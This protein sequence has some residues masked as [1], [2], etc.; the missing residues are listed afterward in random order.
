MEGLQMKQITMEYFTIL[1]LKKL[2]LNNNCID[3]G[4]TESD[5]TFI[6]VKPG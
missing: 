5:N 1:L 3:K 6:I 4:L 2:N